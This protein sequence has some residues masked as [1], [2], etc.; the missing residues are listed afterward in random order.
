MNEKRKKKGKGKEWGTSPGDISTKN[1]KF[2]KKNLQR[3]PVQRPEEEQKVSNAHDSSK[4]EEENNG[5]CSNC[6]STVPWYGTNWYQVVIVVIG[7][8]QQ[9]SLY[10]YYRMRLNF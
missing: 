9:F 3:V 10:Y 2:V 1:D 5:N 8:L 4:E 7:I 6:N